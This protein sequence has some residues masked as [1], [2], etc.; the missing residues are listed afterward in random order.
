MGESRVFR[1]ALTL[2]VGSVGALLFQVLGLPLP[3][4]LGALTATMA[5]SLSGAPVEI[6]PG[7]R[8]YLVCILG[9]M[10]GGTF[11]P[12]VM[13]RWGSGCRRLPLR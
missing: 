12:E 11:S 3:W 1:V 7:L 9:V 8:R 5:A 4:L 2:A 13:A 6:R 10:L